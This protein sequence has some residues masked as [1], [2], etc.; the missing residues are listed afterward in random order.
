[1]VL[2]G[3]FGMVFGFAICVFLF[4][5]YLIL[6]VGLVVGVS[7]VVVGVCGGLCLGFWALCC[8]MRFDYGLVG[9]LV[10]LWV[11]WFWVFWF[12]VCCDFGFGIDCALLCGWW[13]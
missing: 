8:R 6:G 11:W 13:F 5:V 10:W 3:G 7:L 1:M 9:A 2:F 4:V 12:S